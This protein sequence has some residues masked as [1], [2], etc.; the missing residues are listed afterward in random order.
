MAL[1]TTPVQA[2]NSTPN[3]VDTRLENLLMREKIALNNQADRLARTGEVIDRTEKLIQKYKD[4]G[5][6]TTELE[7]ALASYQEGI[8]AAQEY[9]GKAA[10]ILANPA[11]FDANGKV[12]NRKQALETVRTAGN[13]LRRAHLEITEATLD[14]RVA[15]RTF[16][17]E[18]KSDETQP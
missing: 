13:A 1:P 18:Y 10:S 17:E 12:V 3:T 5:V 8:Q 4:Q 7:K 11:G 16:I 2:A 15:V 14:L 9:H 6:N